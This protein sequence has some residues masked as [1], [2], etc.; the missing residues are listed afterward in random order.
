MFGFGG[1]DNYGIDRVVGDQ[2]AQLDRRNRSRRGGLQE[3]NDAYP[4]TATGPDMFEALVRLRRQL[5]PD[6]AWWRI[7]DGDGGKRE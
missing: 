4:Y 3:G 1:S 2:V 6:R 7:R 5:E